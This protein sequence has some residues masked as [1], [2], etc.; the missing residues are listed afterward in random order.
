M[1]WEIM[2]FDKDPYDSWKA[3]LSVQTVGSSTIVAQLARFAEDNILPYKSVS[4]VDGDV[5]DIKGKI[6]KLP[7]KRAPEKE[8]FCTLKERQWSGLDERF[9]VDARKYLNDAMLDR[10]H[11]RWVKNVADKLKMDSGAVWHILVQ[12]WC[13]QVLTEKEKGDFV[14]SIRDAL[15][16]DPKHSEHV[17]A[18]PK[19]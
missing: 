12:A 13:S 18:T 2:K 6:V 9:G 17:D 19:S 3:K 5:Q 16:N 1:F 10:D 8:V 15:H 7:G 14:Q 11:H 4:I